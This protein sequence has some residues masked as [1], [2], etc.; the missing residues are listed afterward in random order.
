MRTTV[1]TTSLT[2]RCR[3]TGVATLDYILVMG[4]ILPLAVVVIPAGKHIL[5]LV[6][7][8]SCVLVAWPFL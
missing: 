8:M 3:R 1:H 7:E 5:E 4:I 6:Y 2:A